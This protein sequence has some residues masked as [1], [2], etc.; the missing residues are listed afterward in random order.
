MGVVMPHR[1]IS[2]NVSLKHVIGC[3]LLRGCDAT[4]VLGAIKLAAAEVD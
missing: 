2:Y 3:V 1:I 4:E